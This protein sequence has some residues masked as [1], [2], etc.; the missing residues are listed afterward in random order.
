MSAIGT[1]LRSFALDNEYLADQLGPRLRPVHLEQGDE[2]EAVSATYLTISDTPD[3]CLTGE[4]GHTQSRIQYDVYANDE[5]LAERVA[6][7]LRQRILL[8]FGEL[9][10]DDDETI[11]CTGISTASG[12]RDLS[13]LTP[14]DGGP[15]WK[16][17]ISFDLYVG[18]NPVE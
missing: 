3:E 14:D 2:D 5:Q 9:T 17:R 13:A 16:H 8:A 11:Y 1:A 18:Y 6:R 12:I 4:V 15:D 7:R 10:A